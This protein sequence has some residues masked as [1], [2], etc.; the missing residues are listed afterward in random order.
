MR[1][2]SFFGP[3]PLGIAITAII[4]ILIVAVIFVGVNV[5]LAFSGGPGPCTAGN[6]PITVNA[7]NASTF[8][9]KWD[10]FDVIL[11]GGSP[12]AATFNESEISSRA[13][14]YISDETDVDFKDV[15]I[16]IH[17][18]FG[19]ATAK[20]GAILGLETKVKISGTVD[21]TGDTPQAQLDD[22]EIGNV[23]GFI[24]DIVEGQVEDAV[25]EALE[26]IDLS[27]T[28]TPTLVEGEAQIDGVP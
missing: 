4:V 15:R 1:F 12:S 19:E 21:L 8:Q 22:I 9:E 6:P 10:A 25:D 5:V 28:Y 26:N 27:H 11:D 23:P 7:A 18:G 16:C 20:L 13:D 14:E 2:M 3:S 17:D 24:V